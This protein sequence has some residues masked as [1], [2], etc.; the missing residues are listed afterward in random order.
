MNFETIYPAAPLEWFALLTAISPLLIG[1]VAALWKVGTYYNEWKSVQW[2]RLQ[3]LIIILYNKDGDYGGWAQVAAV[4]ELETLGVP[5]RTVFVVAD[6]ARA[7][8]ED[9]GASRGIINELIRVSVRNEGF[10]LKRVWRRIW[11]P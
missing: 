11:N 7:H 9:I 1:A 6:R 4:R 8:W 10:L 5:A 3:E 2:R